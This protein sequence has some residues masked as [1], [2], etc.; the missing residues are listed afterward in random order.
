MRRVAAR[1][2]APFLAVVLL[3]TACDG[4]DDEGEGGSDS[5]PNAIDVVMGP[6]YANE[7]FTPVEAPTAEIC[8]RLAADLL[9]RYLTADE[10]E[11]ECEGRSVD[12]IARRFQSRDEYLVVSE[13]HWR[14]RM[15]ANDVN[16]DW[17]Y[18]KEA[19][20]LVDDLHRGDLGYSDFTVEM[21][22]HPAF[23]GGMFEPGE[24]AAH[25]FRA[26]LGR[27]A[28]DAEIADFAALYRPWIPQQ[29]YDADF[30][31]AYRVT[32]NVFPLLCNPD[33]TTC[34]ADL[35]G[36]GALDMDPFDVLS[37][38]FIAYEDLS[39]SQLSSMQEPGRVLVRQ[40][41]FWEAAADEIL[42]R[43][44][45]WSDGGRFPREPG[46]VLPEVRQV[47]ATH[48]RETGDYPSAERLVLTSWLYRQQ[49]AVPDD[50]LGDDPNAVIP[51]IWQH[52]PVK[53]ATAE[54]WLDSIKPLTYDIGTCDP[55]YSDFFPYFVLE[56]E[57][58]LEGMSAAEIAED[59]R[60]L[61]EMQESR[62]PWNDFD[63]FP[64]YTYTYVARLI[65]G[66]PGF[67]ARRQPQT[68]LSYAFTQESVAE[69]LCNTDVATG[70]GDDG[71]VD[72]L[73]DH[74]MRLAFGRSPDAEET[75]IFVAEAENCVGAECTAGALRNSVC[76]G[77][78]GAAEM[79][80]Y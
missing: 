8:R 46:I 36:G 76:V 21:A 23:H 18:L 16:V 32:V 52:G 41:A 75:A 61:W 33:L 28:T 24:K 54:V 17:R 44:L 40:A 47:V 62:V 50:G 59:H 71:A 51:P 15:D 77:L 37:K 4:G 69:Y 70:L 12:E 80:F 31:Y 57:G 38:E 14:D 78:L 5:G 34:A 30:P 6:I 48:L 58:T 26:F 56:E 22:S 53:P 74:Q 73:L 60:R 63:S 67:Q 7:G 66:C 27:E 79:I 65:G 49:A 64:D 3:G 25:A 68:G 13:R 11:T 20:A 2:A 19:F 39:A 9:G 42:N 43:L 45:G 29:A 10:V 55:R 1:V 72:D 35:M